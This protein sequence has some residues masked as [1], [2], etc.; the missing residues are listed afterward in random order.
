MEQMLKQVG[1]LL[2]CAAVLV[3]TADVAL[4]QGQP[5]VIKWRMQ[6]IDPRP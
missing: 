6:S 1:V 5:Q 4:A 3:L 2:I